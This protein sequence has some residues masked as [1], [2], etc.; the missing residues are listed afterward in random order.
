MVFDFLNLFGYWQWFST[1]PDDLPIESGGRAAGGGG[2]RVQ[3]VD[4]TWN[5]DIPAVT[6]RLGT[7]PGGTAWAG[8]S[9]PGQ[10][11]REVLTRL[12]QKTPAEIA[13]LI[14]AGTIV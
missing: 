4:D 2:R 6:P 7:T 14:E 12:L 10:D 11:T 3:V 13:A 5:L 8:R 9:T 1:K